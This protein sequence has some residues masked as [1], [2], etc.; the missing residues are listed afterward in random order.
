MN[1]GFKGRNNPYI[2]LSDTCNVIE[3]SDQFKLSRGRQ[4][5]M[6]TVFR[7]LSAADVERLRAFCRESCAPPEDPLSDLKN[8]IA[9]PLRY[10][11]Y[12]YAVALK[13]PELR[14]P[15]TVLYL[16]DRALTGRKA[17]GLLF[18]RIPPSVA[19]IINGMGGST[20]LN[21][22]VSYLLSSGETIRVCDTEKLIESMIAKLTQR[23]KRLNS[24]L[25]FD[26]CD[27]IGR[28]DSTL[29]CGRIRLGAFVMLFVSLVSVLDLAVSQPHISVR[30]NRYSDSAEVVISGETGINFPFVGSTADIMSLAK[31]I[32]GSCSMLAFAT[33]TASENDMYIGFQTNVAGH[34]LR[35]Y[36]GFVPDT[37]SELEFKYRDPEPEINEMMN[38]AIA[39]VESPAVT[40][41]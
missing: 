3:V 2:I 19:S 31:Y 8:S 32:H 36:F 23:G 39:I 25:V 1:I 16:T 5:D 26:G 30:L 12:K 41:I 15:V 34:S 38:R 14:D 4:I 29:Q 20:D 18:D 7:Y 37:P 35:L 10:L 22:S 21:E 13:L 28:L 24:D 40:M 33:Y 6:E 27:D 11:T 9:F 17:R